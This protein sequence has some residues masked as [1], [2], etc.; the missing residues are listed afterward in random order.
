MTPIN[1][2][3]KDL[4]L[5]H[6]CVTL[7]GLGG[8]LIQQ[9]TAQIE[10]GGTADHFSPPRRGL[11]FDRSYAGDD[12]VLA[13][14]MLLAGAADLDQ[15]RAQVQEQVHAIGEALNLGQK[16]DF[17]G[18]GI[19]AKIDGALVFM[20]DPESELLAE[21][22]GFEG[23]KMEPLDKPKAAT[24][25]ATVVKPQEEEEDEKKPILL[26]AALL[27]VLLLLVFIG[28]QTK[29]FDFG[30]RRQAQVD[31]PAADSSAN[32]AQ[33]TT[34]APDSA[35]TAPVAELA[36]DTA[37]RPNPPQTPAVEV[38]I[39]ENGQE[40]FFLVVGS[41]KVRENATRLNQQL[42]AAGYNSRILP[43]GDF[44]RVTMSG[45]ANREQAASE[46]QKLMADKTEVWLL[47]N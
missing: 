33:N 8:F 36:P 39:D 18:V 40:R 31:A 12:G 5:K 26:I 45:F 1:P 30:S 20:P 44:H 10:Q 42:K 17:P 34:Q 27:L 32:T 3:I 41:F 7:P 29:L 19:L 14:A 16:V 22:L 4:L 28:F 24:M 25:A 15:A 47:D 46:Y 13:N 11:A 2:L 35:A 43:F 9:Q 6:D 23:F 21:T 37:A 38:E